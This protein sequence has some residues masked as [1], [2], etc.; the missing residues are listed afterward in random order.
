MG[1]QLVLTSHCDERPTSATRPLSWQT[2]LYDQVIVMSDQPVLTINCDV[3]PPCFNE[4]LW[5]EATLFYKATIMRCHLVTV[6]STHYIEYL[7]VQ[8]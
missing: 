3:R 6:L 1:D 4:Q 5:C 8:I 2:N 7:Q